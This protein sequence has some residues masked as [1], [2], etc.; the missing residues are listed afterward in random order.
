MEINIISLI[1]GMFAGTAI[2]G[3]IMLVAMYGER[4]CAGFGEGYKAAME[5]EKKNED[6][7]C[8]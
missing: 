7:Y 6:D 3:A 2:T 8:I 4:W 1:I 5:K